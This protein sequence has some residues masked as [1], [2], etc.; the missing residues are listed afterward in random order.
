MR[1]RSWPIV[2]AV[3][4]CG[5]TGEKGAT[6]PTEKHD[7]PTRLARV[8]LPKHAEMLAWSAD[9]K[10]LA[11]AGSSGPSVDMPK[12]S[13]LFIVD[14]DKEAIAAKLQVLSLVKVLAFSPDGKWLAVSAETWGADQQAVA[15]EMVVFDIPA[16]TAKFK[17]Q[18]IRLKNAFTDLAWSADSKVLHA[19]DGQDAREGNQEFRRWEV[20]DFTEQP[21]IK[22]DKPQNIDY[23]ALA[24]SPDGQMLAIAEKTVLNHLMIRIFTLAKGTG[25]TAFKVAETVDS[26]RLGYSADGKEIGVLNGATLS[27]WNA[28]TGQSATPDPARFSVRPP[29]YPLSPDTATWGCVPSLKTVFLAISVPPLT[30]AI[31]SLAPSSN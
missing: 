1:N 10:Y 17:A 8:S 22:V 21:S 13:E 5:C 26:P 15:A 12:S 28:A 20:V 27:W 11:A 29:S 30:G 4:V 16:F 14:I 9:G 7:P 31:R 3:G 25:S 24:A 23:K 19:I 18:A 6:N 2:L